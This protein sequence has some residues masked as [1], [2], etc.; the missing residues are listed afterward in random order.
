MRVTYLYPRRKRLSFTLIAKKHVEQLRKRGYEVHEAD[1]HMFSSADLSDVTLVH[2]MFY[3]LIDS[4]R[5]YKILIKYGKKLVGFDVCDT[6]KITPLAAYI[7]N[8]FDTVIVPTRYCRDVYKASGVMT[9]I[10]VLPH[11][12]D[13]VFLR[14]PREP[15]D[16]DV[17]KIHD[18]RG[19]KIL[20]FLWHSGFR[21]GADV[22]A[23]A[24]A[25]LVKEFRD[26]YLIVKIAGIW[27]PLLQYMFNIP[28]VKIFNKWL[29]DDDLVDLY[30]SVDIVVCPSRGG[31]FELNALEALARGKVTIVSSWGAFNDYCRECL[32][33]SSRGTIDLF[34]GDRIAKAIHDGKG[35]DPDPN[36]LY[37]KLR[38]ALY[39]LDTYKKRFERLAQ[40]VRKNYTWDKVGNHLSEIIESVAT[41][42]TLT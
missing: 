34:L 32:R 20:F 31:G 25:R 2:P 3:P 41:K 15:R 8:L 10:R 12:I 39:T 21:K 14:E 5:R 40:F 17:R 24:F 27:D 9:D 6:S 4:P 36:D 18:L 37:M 28:N 29:S 26:V 23:E 1:I 33:V 16:P 42:A 7:A 11:G 13:D 35:V 19:T 22:V 30:D 38:M